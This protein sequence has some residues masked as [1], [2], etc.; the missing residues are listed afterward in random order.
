MF[1]SCF[2]LLT[3]EHASSLGSCL[4]SP[5]VNI[6]KYL[7]TKNGN[8]VGSNPYYNFVDSG[9]LCTLCHQNTLQNC[10]AFYAKYSA[11]LYGFLLCKIVCFIRKILCN[12]VWF[13][14]C[15]IVWFFMAKILMVFSD[16][17]L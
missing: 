15:E 11:K 3:S 12:I 1:V 14:L 8:R 2:G 16:Y 6:V 13:L 7:Y 10:M 17:A 5:F 4:T 9:K